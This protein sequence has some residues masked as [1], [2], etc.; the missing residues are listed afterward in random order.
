LNRGLP[1]VLVN[2]R[3]VISVHDAKMLPEDEAEAWR[4]M[5]AI[6]QKGVKQLHSVSI[7]ASQEFE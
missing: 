2:N 4:F 6:R 7:V 5:E 1:V 3:I